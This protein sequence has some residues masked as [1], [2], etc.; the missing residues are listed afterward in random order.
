[1][2]ELIISSIVNIAGCAFSVGAAA[3]LSTRS[4]FV[5]ILAASAVVW[6]GSFA[7]GLTTTLL[8]WLPR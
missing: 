8:K 3:Y 7:I 2:D 6:A 1:M 4:W 5:S